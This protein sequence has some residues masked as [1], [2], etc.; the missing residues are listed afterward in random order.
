MGVPNHPQ[1]QGTIEA[2]NKTIQRALSFAY[3]NV[4]LEEIEWDLELNL[5]NFLHFYNGIWR[6]ITT[7]EVP[8]VFYE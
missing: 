8:K 3:V 5:F 7:N 4:K 6:H 1:S 2:Y